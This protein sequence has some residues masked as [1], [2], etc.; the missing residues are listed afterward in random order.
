MNYFRKAKELG[1][2][3]PKV[4]QLC[5]LSPRVQPAEARCSGGVYLVLRLDLDIRT[6]L[7][8]HDESEGK[9]I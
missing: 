5:D 2:S 9:R 4:A 3:S 7:H 1:E 8:D 6:V